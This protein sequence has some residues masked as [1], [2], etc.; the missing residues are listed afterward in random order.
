MHHTIEKRAMHHPTSIQLSRSTAHS[1]RGETRAVLGRRTWTVAGLCLTAAF[2]AAVAAAAQ[3]VVPGPIPSAVAVGSSLPIASGVDVAG[4]GTTAHALP[5]LTQPHAVRSGDDARLRRTISI[6]QPDG[7]TLPALFSQLSA[8]SGVR[9]VQGEGTRDVYTGTLSIICRNAPVEAVMDALACYYKDAWGH[10]SAKR[11]SQLGEYLFRLDDQ[12]FYPEFGPFLRLAD[13]MVMPMSDAERAWFA[14]ASP[15]IDGMSDHTSAGSPAVAA[16]FF[17]AGGVAVAELPAWAQ[18]RVRQLIAMNRASHVNGPMAGFQ[19]TDAELQQIR[20]GAQR[21]FGAPAAFNDYSL[22]MQDGDRWRMSARTNEYEAWKRALPR[23]LAKTADGTTI[24]TWSAGA[25]ELTSV[26]ARTA[27]ALNQTV[28][29]HLKRVSLPEALEELSR[30]YGLW[31]VCDGNEVLWCDEDVDL[32]RMTLADGLA[33]LA[34]TNAST[35][36]EW[37]PGGFLVV[38]GPE[39]Q[40]AAKLQ[41]YDAAAPQAQ[42]IGVPTIR[43]TA[44][45]TLPDLHRM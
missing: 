20:I 36:W 14:A 24:E 6:S 22:Q 4:G 19:M 38:R 5:G 31:F 45:S 37:R 23:P 9:I 35:Q 27:Y 42:Q 39:G 25:G 7:A 32:S 18:A 13:D 30:R 10:I 33:A 28:E 44:R 15:L 41:P 2:G 3:Q 29:V 43:G 17:S 16:A 34:K 1:S 40:C 12:G 26:C 11:R 21:Q 8:A